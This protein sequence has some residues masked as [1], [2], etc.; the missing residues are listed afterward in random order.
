LV[1]H[2]FHMRILKPDGKGFRYG[3][4]TWVSHE[5]KNLSL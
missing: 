1:S 2:G 5:G 4:F 3:G